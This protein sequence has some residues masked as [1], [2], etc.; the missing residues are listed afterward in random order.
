MAQR[1]GL[2]QKSDGAEVEKVAKGIIEANPSV[3]EEY[4][5]GKVSSIQFLLGQAMKETKGSINPQVLKSAFEK[6]LSD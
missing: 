4:K 1:E 3:A 6:L 5:A 2:L